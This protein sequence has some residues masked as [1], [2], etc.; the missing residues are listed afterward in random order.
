MCMEFNFD[1]ENVENYVSLGWVVNQMKGKLGTSFSK[2]AVVVLLSPETH[3]TAKLDH[4]GC[5]LKVR[6]FL[7]KCILKRLDSNDLKVKLQYY[8]R[9]SA[10]VETF[11]VGFQQ[12]KRVE[13]TV[14]VGD[15]RS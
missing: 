3:V 13:K 5:Y 8:L 6:E 9:S 4:E 12:A 14:L 1:W 7:H 2:D 10:V 15:V 11:A